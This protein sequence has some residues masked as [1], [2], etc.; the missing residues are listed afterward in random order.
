MDQNRAD[1]AMNRSLPLL[2]NTIPLERDVF[3]RTLI[4]HLAGSLQEIVGLKEAEGFITIV[5]QRMGDEIDQMYRSALEVP[6][7]SRQQVAE[8]CVDLKRRIN[9]KFEVLEQTDEKIVFGNSACPFGEKVRDR[10]ALCMMTSNVFG[11]IAAENVGYGKVVL[12]KTI[13]RGDAGCRVVVY[14]QRTAN[15]SAAEGREY[16]GSE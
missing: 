13:A 11:T 6:R 9:G 8:V 2:P 3:L 15:A 4:R 5:G 7:L 1:D 10:P 16:I 14:L 12:E